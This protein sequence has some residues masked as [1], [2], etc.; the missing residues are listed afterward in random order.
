M[1]RFLFIILI[2][3]L[4]APGWCGDISETIRT[5]H[6]GEKS[7]QSQFTER[8]IMPKAHKES[9]KRG[10][11]YYQ[12][13]ESLLML[14]TEPRGDYSLI[15]GGKFTARRGGKKTDFPMNASRPD[16]MYILRETLLGSLSGD[17]ARVAKQNN[18]D[19][20]C[21]DQ[22]KTYLCTLTKRETPRSGVNRLELRYDKSTGALLELR[23]IQV[24]GNYTSY[25]THEGKRNIVIPSSVWK[26]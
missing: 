3:V 1:K 22:G 12:S 20:Q 17:L 18:A 19:I 8:T 7:Y 21:A 15:R 4:S 11:M 9:V 24:N 5:L 13:D 14:Y 2:S 23:L 26:P 6:S 10:T 25:E 16:R